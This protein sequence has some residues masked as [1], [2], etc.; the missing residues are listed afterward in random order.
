MAINQKRFGNQMEKALEKFIQ[1]APDAPTQDKPAKQASAQNEDGVQIT[2]RLSKE[3]LQRLTRMAKRQGI[4]RASYIKR[5][6]FLQLEG[7]E[8]K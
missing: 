3:Q 2:L 7:D 6:V 8:A 1:T 5:A 4:A